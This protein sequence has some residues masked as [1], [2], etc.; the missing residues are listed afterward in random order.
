MQDTENMEDVGQPSWSGVISMGQ[1]L[2]QLRQER[3]LSL[4]ELARLTG[5][6]AA[7]LNRL[8]LDPTANPTLSTLLSLAR[9]FN[10]HSVEELFGPFPTEEA[11]SNSGHDPAD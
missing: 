11:I 8:E 7:T 1:R 4:R 10:L 3:G 6:S 5:T 2:Y 9:V